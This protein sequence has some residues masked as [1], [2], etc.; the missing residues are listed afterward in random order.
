VIVDAAKG[1]GNAREFWLARLSGA[2]LL[3]TAIILAVL[4]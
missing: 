4:K 2:A 3:L 1:E